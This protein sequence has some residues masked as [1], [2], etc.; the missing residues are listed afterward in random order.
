LADNNSVATGEVAFDLG[1]VGYSY[2]VRVDSLAM[3]SGQCLSSYNLMKPIEYR[4]T[5]MVV[6]TVKPLLV[7]VSTCQN[8]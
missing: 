7:H 4:S 6:D 2:H 1:V 3:R 5:Y 8:A